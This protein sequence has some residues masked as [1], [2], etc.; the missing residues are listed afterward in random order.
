MAAMRTAG[1][2]AIELAREGKRVAKIELHRLG[3][4][5][6]FLE[7]AGFGL[8]LDVADGQRTQSQRAV[9]RKL[10]AVRLHVQALDA[11]RWHRI[12][13]GGDQQM[14][15]GDKLRL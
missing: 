9:R 2:S 12:D 11:T 6:H 1:A 15:G 13:V 5:N 8:I 14:L 4:G 3:G 10:L 7:Q